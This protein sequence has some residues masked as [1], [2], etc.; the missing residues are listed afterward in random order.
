MP[1][2][3]DDMTNVNVQ[4]KAYTPKFFSDLFTGSGKKVGLFSEHVNPSRLPD[5]LQATDD[6]LNGRKKRITN[7]DTVTNIIPVNTLP[8]SEWKYMKNRD[9]PPLP[10][11]GYLAQ[12]TQKG[13]PVDMYVDIELHSVVQ[14]ETKVT[15]YSGAVSTSK[16]NE[17]VYQVTY[18]Y[19]TD[20]T[21]PKV[22]RCDTGYGVD[23]RQT[24]QT[25][26]TRTPAQLIR[27]HIDNLEKYIILQQNSTFTKDDA[28]I[29]R[30]L[31]NWSAY[32]IACNRARQ[33]QE[34][35]HEVVGQYV[36]FVY[37]YVAT[38]HATHYDTRMFV[39]LAAPVIRRLENYRVPLDVY[40]SLYEI[41]RREL[42]VDEAT[43]L[44]KQNLNLLLS[45]TLHNL[46]T[47]R[48]SLQRLTVPNPP[49]N[50]AMSLRR[51]SP[52]QINAI[53][54]D[55]SL[56]LVQAGAGTGKSTVILGR[57]DYLCEVGVDPKDI[58]VLSFTNA[59]ADNITAK[60]PHVNSMT[61]ARMIHTIYET[62]FPNHVL[63]SPD[64][65]HNSLDIYYP[66]SVHR[67]NVVTEFQHALRG[68]IKNDNN[69]FT[70]M[71]NLVEDHYDEIIEIL[72]TLKQTSLE[73]EIIICYQQID[74]FQEPPEVQSRY[75]I[76][77]EV[78]DNSIF[79]F[80]YTLKYVDKNKQ[81]LF[82]VG[83]SSQTLYEFRASNPRALN[84]M[85][86]SGIF[87]TFQLQTNYR[88]NQEILDFA[89]IALENIEAN[90][91]AGI[92]L[93][94]NSLAKVT[95]K[96]FQEKVQ[97]QYTPLPKLTDLND[98]LPLMLLD[99]KHFIDEKIQNSEQVAFLAFTRHNIWMMQ[100]WLEKHYPGK[101]CVSLV[102]ERMHNS[103]VFSD[104][105]RRYWDDLKFSPAANILTTIGSELMQK[106]QYFLRGNVAKQEEAIRKM[107][108]EWHN[109]MKPTVDNWFAQ[110]TNGVLSKD[111][112]LLLVRDSMLEFEISYNSIRQS[113]M[114]SRNEKAKR[115]QA[116]NGADFILS[117]IHSA[118]GLE[119]E[120]TVVLY[121]DESGMDE[122]KKRMYYVAFT[123]AMKSEMILAYGTVKSP[124]IEGNY[125]TVLRKLRAANPT[126]IA[127][128]V[129]GDDHEDE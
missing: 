129:A 90:Q 64:T 17:I 21:N 88:S 34:D 114:S 128:S 48:A 40:R 71:N 13:D 65:I 62:N 30:L 107:R 76:I 63:S 116:A 47:N 108:I 91:Y 39:E 93:Q 94:A 100:Q 4:R 80:V 70:L 109:Q 55:E 115:Q 98:T 97:V 72:D 58:T 99:A 9:L 18:Y 112:F 96:T 61:I 6:A 7:G 12:F 75:L 125:E 45:D 27:Q 43:A 85:E 68:I 35:I 37:D 110:Y 103:T 123:R 50:V 73:L 87:A 24:Y 8:M 36:K 95:P 10:S 111:D 38:N 92:Q 23:Y 126:R 26:F 15:K 102:P 16:E 124:Q 31:D 60:N 32:D 46:N 1:I 79:E 117:T 104:F 69:A 84:I 89:N 57:I 120:N 78:Q 28:A 53:T 86:G 119:F 118:K 41:I 54:T 33:W 82:I 44:C 3:L 127:K 121:K 59:A 83:D 105:I 77:D 25:E 122:E 113:L 49:T 14:T 101:V 20:P 74:N 22:N 2:I 19:V 42:P 51:Y 67:S 29:N 66:P 5:S 106:L 11:I 81:S 56:T 52:E